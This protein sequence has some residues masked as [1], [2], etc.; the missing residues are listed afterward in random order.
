[1][2]LSGTNDNIAWWDLYISEEGD[3]LNMCRTLSVE[4]SVEWPGWT[5][6]RGSGVKGTGKG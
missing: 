4:I 1:M 3:D 2:S 5:L 6:G